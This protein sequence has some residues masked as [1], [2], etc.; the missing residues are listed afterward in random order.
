VRYAGAQEPEDMPVLL[1]AA[2]LFVWPAINEAWG[3]AILEAQAAGLPVVAGRFGGV[4][5]LVADGSTGLVTS[6]RDV[7]AFTASVGALLRDAER[8]QRFGA[9]ARAK[10]AAE[11]DVPAA[12]AALDTIFATVTKVQA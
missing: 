9:A 10:V 12:G 4:P 8:R 1:A 2:D 6:P 11:H 3:M 7:A 5:V